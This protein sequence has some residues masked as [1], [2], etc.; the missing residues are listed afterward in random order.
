[1]IMNRFTF[2]LGLAGALALPFATGCG[3][4]ANDK[5]VG[6]GTGG[7]GGGATGESLA[8]GEN[9]HDH[10]MD[11]HQPG[12]DG[13]DTQSPLEVKQLE[14]TVGTPEVVARLHGCTKITYAGL[15]S[16][17]SSR[18]VNVANQ[19][20]NSAGVIYRG[21]SAA[22]GLANYG[23]RV[24][25]ALFS[26]TSAMAKQFDIMIAASSEVLANLATST[27]CQGVALVAN[28][29]LTRDG[30]SCI[31]GKPAKDEHVA[32][33]NN[34]IAQ[35]PDPATGQRLAISALLEAAHTCE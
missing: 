14:Q 31:L 13:V 23:G 11:G 15:G 10:A 32:L 35:A 26:S 2:V 6:G 25:E 24:P 4:D 1:M 17:L 8:S 34:L 19:A 20:A 18:G 3:A 28:N 27:G 30:I 16:I 21:G 29:Q 5:L 7:N 22:L 9:T 12:A 33:A